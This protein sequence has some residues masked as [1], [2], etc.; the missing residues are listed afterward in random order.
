MDD[1]DDCDDND[2]DDADISSLRVRTRR[3]S[4]PPYRHLGS[5]LGGVRILS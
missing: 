4:D 5:A 2:N 3:S 1:D